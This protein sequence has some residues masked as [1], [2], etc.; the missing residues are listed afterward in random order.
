MILHVAKETKK[1]PYE[2]RTLKRSMSLIEEEV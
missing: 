1:S 2:D